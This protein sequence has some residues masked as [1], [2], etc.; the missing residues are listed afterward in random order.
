MSD[1]M[2]SEDRRAKLQ[3]M[4]S[5]RSHERRA[6]SIFSE[7]SKDTQLLSAVTWDIF[8]PPPINSIKVIP[9]CILGGGAPCIQPYLFLFSHL[10]LAGKVTS[11]LFESLQTPSKVVH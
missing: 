1:N 9:L 11:E 8:C 10:I 7:A 4:K 3:R 2:A 6:E 5:K